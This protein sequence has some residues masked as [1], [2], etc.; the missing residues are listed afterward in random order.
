MLWTFG[1]I[2]HLC[3]LFIWLEF[4]LTVP[5][6]EIPGQPGKTSVPVSGG[7]KNYVSQETL[8]LPTSRLTVNSSNFS[9]VD[10]NSLQYACMGFPLL[11]LATWL[12][13]P[14]PSALPS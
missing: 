10:Q 11:F 13:T 7:E 9:L 6:R 14:L 4:G 3:G 12:E 1:G 5:L 8:I 2:I